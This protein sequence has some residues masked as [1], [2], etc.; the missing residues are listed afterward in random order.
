MGD[1]A[2]SHELLSVVAAVHHQGVGQALDDWALCLA[3]TLDGVPAGGVG[4]VDGLADLDVVAVVRFSSA[5]II[6][7]TP[8]SSLTALG[9]V[10]EGDIPDLDV[11]VAPLVEQLHAANLAG[12]ILWQDW[13]ALGRLNFDLAAVRHICN[14]WSGGW[15]AVSVG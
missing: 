1:D 13:V 5:P 12:D 2:D 7:T 6:H 3:E 10:R 4:D 9:D 8:Y 11:L 14:W 15:S